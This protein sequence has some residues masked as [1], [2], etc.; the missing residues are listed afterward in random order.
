ML[1]QP[2]R[3][4]LRKGTLQ[5]MSRK[6]LTQRM[7]FLVSVVVVYCGNA[8]PDS[9]GVFGKGSLMMLAAMV[10]LYLITGGVIHDMVYLPSPVLRCAAAYLPGSQW[11]LQVQG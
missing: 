5:K 10:I 1:L 4:F 8:S 11:C 9:I 7:F 3:V 6:S 2:S